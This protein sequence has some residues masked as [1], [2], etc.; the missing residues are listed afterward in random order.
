MSI[1]KPG[2][3]SKATDGAAVDGVPMRGWMSGSRMFMS[4]VPEK[5][6]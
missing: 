6:G 5:A 3:S 2:G 4:A 1:M